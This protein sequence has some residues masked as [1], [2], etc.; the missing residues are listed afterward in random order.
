MVR[1]FER[2]GCVL[3]FGASGE[4]N[5]MSREERSELTSRFQTCVRTTTCG[6][7]K[8]TRGLVVI[9]CESRGALRFAPATLTHQ[10]R[11]ITTPESLSSMAA[12]I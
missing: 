8:A 11:E 1:I 10:R 3:S 2:I 7:G 12:P 5:V 9:A 6:R 4:D